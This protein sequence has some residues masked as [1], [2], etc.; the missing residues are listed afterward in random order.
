VELT[1]DEWSELLAMVTS[2]DVAA[3]VATRARIVLWRAEGRQKKDVAAVAGVSRPTVDLWLERYA[4][5]G[6]AGLLDRSHAAPREQVP[7][8]LQATIAVPVRRWGIGAEDFPTVRWSTWW[9][10]I[11]G[12]TFR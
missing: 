8:V 5:E 6:V 4:V 9:C 12:R 10:A 3:T 2:P 7:A 11:D 1:T